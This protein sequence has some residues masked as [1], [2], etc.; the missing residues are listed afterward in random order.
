VALRSHDGNK[1]CFGR[2][3]K[4]QLHPRIHGGGAC[5]DSVGT[6]RDPLSPDCVGRPWHRAQPLR[7]RATPFEQGCCPGCTYEAGQDPS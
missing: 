6:A 7:R 3:Y 1:R 2:P 5:R 4:D